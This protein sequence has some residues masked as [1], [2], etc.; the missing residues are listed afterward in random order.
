[1]KVG[2]AGRRRLRRAYTLAEVERLCA[3]ATREGTRVVYRVAA[4]SGFRRG[5]MRR[6]KKEDCTPTGERPRWHVNAANTKDKQPVNL[7][8]TPDCA[9]ALREWW[10]ALP[11]GSPLLT[12]PDKKAFLDQQQRAGIARV[13]ERGRHADFHSLRYTFC[14][15]LSRKYPI[16]V[17]AKLMRHGT[18]NLT[19]G[20]YLDLG[21]DRQGEGERVLN[22]LSGEVVGS[23]NASANTLE[24]TKAEEKGES[25]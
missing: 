21:L 19:M 16:E 17:V 23:A 15:L 3:A 5:E 24:I 14:T 12:V 20:I 2:Q 9:E 8:M 22:R 1:V 7:P 4:F 18:I 10:S 25:T 6:L 13:D 11:A